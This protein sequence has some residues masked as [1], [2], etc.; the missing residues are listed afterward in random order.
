MKHCWEMKIEMYVSAAQRLVILF[1]RYYTTRGN[2][3]NWINSNPF[4]N[5]YE[6]WVV[7]VVMMW[8]SLN[9]NSPITLNVCDDWMWCGSSSNTQGVW[10][11]KNRRTKTKVHFNSPQKHVSHMGGVAHI[12]KFYWLAFY[13]SAKFI[14]LISKLIFLF[15]SQEKFL[16]PNFISLLGLFVHKRCPIL[17]IERGTIKICFIWCKIPVRN[18][19][20]A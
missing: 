13:R 7:V 16:W 3:L 12:V 2:A 15:I 1:D 17:G 5:M 18:L 10:H 9:L 6:G 19:N 8:H 4:C 11:K 14:F 20:I